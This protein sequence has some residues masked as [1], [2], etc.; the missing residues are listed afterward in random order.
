[1][2][3]KTFSSVG[4][5][6][7]FSS[8]NWDAAFVGLEL[9]E[10]CVAAKE[11][12][13]VSAKKKHIVE[14][15]VKQPHRLKF[16]SQLLP[17]KGLVGA[18]KGYKSIVLEA[19]S[20]GTVE[21]LHLLR[22]A[23][24]AG[25]RTVDC[26][27]VEPRDYEKDTYLDTSWSRDFSLSSSHRI[28]GVPGFLSTQG[29]LENHHVRLVAFLGYESSRLAAAAQ[30]ELSMADWIKYAVIGVPGFAPGWEIN[31]LA[32]NIDELDTQQF[33][34]IQYCAASSV[35]SALD[36]LRRIHKEGNR[37][38]PH[39]VVAPMGT[40]PHGIAAA[41][42]LVENSG[43]QESSLLYDH[44]LRARG[45]TTEVRRWHLFRIDL[46]ST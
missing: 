33:C 30:Q 9:D 31:T 15:S 18:L 27:Y 10:R 5:E 44:P 14:Y 23:K 41:I 13:C 36:L 24:V 35:S 43:F 21:V 1:M 38:T 4:Q 26:L 7:A 11:L 32:N 28:A 2:K 37:D 34:S 6:H 25:V 16:D 29:D 45:R 8:L 22:A 19:T 42:F 3:V 17:H 39:T 12:V 46:C 20:I 40:K